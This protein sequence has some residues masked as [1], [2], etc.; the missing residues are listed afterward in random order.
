MHCYMLSNICCRFMIF[1]NLAWGRLERRCY[2]AGNKQRKSRTD[3]G[4]EVEN[5]NR[6]TREKILNFDESALES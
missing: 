4:A 5:E 1:I 6:R 2:N 3:Y